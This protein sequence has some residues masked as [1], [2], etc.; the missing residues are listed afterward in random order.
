LRLVQLASFADVDAWIQVAC[1]RLSIDWGT[2]FTAPLLTPYEAE[3]A[4]GATA[5]REVYPM[6]YYAR[7]SGTWTNYYAPPGAGDKAGRPRG[8][9]ARAA[10]V[11]RQ[12][13]EIA[14]DRGAASTAAVAPAG[15][16]GAAGALPFATAVAQP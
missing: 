11:R 16:G 9:A 10:A 4:L 12:R 14:V 15:E 7:G 2:G 5:W 6:D 8:A 1:P 3:V 13:V